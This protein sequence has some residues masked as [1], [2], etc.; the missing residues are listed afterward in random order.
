MKKLLVVCFLFLIVVKVFADASDL[1]ITSHATKY[2]STAY[3]ESH[4]PHQAVANK[5]Q[6]EQEADPRLGDM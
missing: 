2:Q 4:K 1:Q 5:A 3:Q 6:A